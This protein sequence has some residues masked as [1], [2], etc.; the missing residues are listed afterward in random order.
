[1]YVVPVYKY[2]ASRI[3]PLAYAIRCKIVDLEIIH[4][5]FHRDKP[6]H[7]HKLMVLKSKNKVQMHKV[8]LSLRKTVFEE[9]GTCKISQHISD[10]VESNDR[11]SHMVFNRNVERTVLAQ[12]LNELNMF[13]H[14]MRNRSTQAHSRNACTHFSPNIHVSYEYST[15]NPFNRRWRRKEDIPNQLSNSWR[16]DT[17]H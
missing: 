1:M 14:R 2:S 6:F 17:R 4:L 3:S 15:Q 7:W 13:T 9:F 5:H 10:R 12:K 8:I 11:H 16:S